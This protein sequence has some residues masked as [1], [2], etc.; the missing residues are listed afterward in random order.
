MGALPRR[1]AF[2]VLHAAGRC[3]NDQRTVLPQPGNNRVDSRGQLDDTAGSRQTLH[4][5]PHVADDHRD[6][7]VIPV[8]S[9]R[10]RGRAVAG[11]GPERHEP[12]GHRLLRRWMLVLSSISAF[13]CTRLTLRRQDHEDTSPA[14]LDRPGPC[15]SDLPER[16]R[17]AHPCAGLASSTRRAPPGACTARSHAQLPGIPRRLATSHPRR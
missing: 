2:V 8:G 13:V 12:E 9:S 5:I 16:D 14:V 6:L 10:D 1:S 4:G 3:V 15:V 17:S 7:G 11:P